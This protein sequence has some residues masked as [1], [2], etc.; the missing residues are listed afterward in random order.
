MKT[1]LIT[2]LAMLSV[3]PHGASAGVDGERSLMFSVH[4][5]GSRI[6]YHRF[7]LVPD[8][9]GIDVVSEARFDVRVLFFDAFTY[10]HRNRES[11]DGQCLET[12]ESETTENDREFAVVGRRIDDRFVLE[13]GGASESLDSCVMTFA[14]WNP[15]FLDQSRLLNP[16]SG[17]YVPVDVEALGERRIVARGETVTAAAYR[18]TAKDRELTVFY[19]DDGKWLGL[20]SVARGGRTI[21]YELT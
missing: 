18:V 7:E 9:E 14:Y 11:W 3:L 20:E 2:I 6:G 21:R 17:E 16:Q 15:A 1:L 10:R 12:I 5:D 13:S 19:S 8:A 4:L